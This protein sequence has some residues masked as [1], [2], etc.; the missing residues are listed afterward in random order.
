MANNYSVDFSRL[1]NQGSAGSMTYW[2][3]VTWHYNRRHTMHR[4]AW[5]G[6]IS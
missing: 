2:S 1:I 6:K 3:G 5:S 4:I